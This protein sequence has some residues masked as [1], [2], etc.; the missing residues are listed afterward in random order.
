M[1]N[2]LIGS[3]NSFNQY[4]A[5]TKGGQ[6]RKTKGETTAKKTHASCHPS[7]SRQKKV[8]NHTPL[9]DLEPRF[10]DTKMG[11]KNALLRITFSLQKVT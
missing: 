4:E 8:E 9:R 10:I 3:E 11:M 5:L 1:A 2:P 7:I 6:F